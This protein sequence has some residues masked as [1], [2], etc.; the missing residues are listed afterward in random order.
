[1][2]AAGLRRAKAVATKRSGRGPVGDPRRMSCAGRSS[3]H[4]HRASRRSAADDSADRRADSAARCTSAR[5][6]RPFQLRPKDLVPDQTAELP[7]RLR[8]DRSDVLRRNALRGGRSARADRRNAGPGRIAL[9]RLLRRSTAQTTIR[10]RTTAR[11][12]RAATPPPSPPAEASPQ[13]QPPA[14]PPPS[15]TGQLPEPPPRARP[16]RRTR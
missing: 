13:N 6:D 3:G 14:P 8:G 5:G 11:S 16:P 4:R 2:T 9:R 12:A 15:P 10:R 7:A 1:M